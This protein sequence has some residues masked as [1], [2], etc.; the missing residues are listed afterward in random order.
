VLDFFFLFFRR[1]VFVVVVEEKRRSGEVLRDFKTV[2]RAEA[3]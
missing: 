2:G 1:F 3:L